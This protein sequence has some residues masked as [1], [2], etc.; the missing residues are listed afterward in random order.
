M[1]ML[2]KPSVQ[3]NIMNPQLKFS[4]Q[5]SEEKKLNQQ[6]LLTKR[7]AEKREVKPNDKVPTGKKQVW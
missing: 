1:V 7:G 4:L 3:S 6:R 2:P 5:K